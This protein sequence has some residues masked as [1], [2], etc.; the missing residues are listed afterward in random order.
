LKSEFAG[1]GFLGNVAATFGTRLLLLIIGIV[2]SV[3]IARALGPTG[4][5]M[6]AAAF[7]VTA[8][9]VQ[10]GNLGLH[11]SNTWLVARDRSLLGG[12][13]TNSLAVSALVGTVGLVI[14]AIVTTL[15][16]SV[17]PI[18][19]SLM[20]LALVSIPVSLAYLLLQNLLL[21]VG[22]IRAY[23]SIEIVNRALVV[24]G[25]VVLAIVGML[26]PFSALAV[27]LV[28]IVAAGAMALGR[29]GAGVRLPLKP[30]RTLLLDSGRYGFKAYL[31]AL[32]AFLVLRLDVLIVQ[33]LSGATATG[34]YAVAAT[35]TESL[36]IFPAVVGTLLFARL[37]ALDDH[38]TR[39]RQAKAA[40]WAVGGLMIVA[41]VLAAVF[42][43]PVIALLY[44][45]AFEPATGAFVWLMP[46]LLFLSMNTVLMNYFASRGMPLVTIAG[47]AIALGA[48]VALNLVLVPTYGIIGAAAASSVAYG[49][50][51]LA[52]I[53]AVWSADRG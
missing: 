8:I 34:Y 46:G 9:G 15:W 26:T 51:L 4:R 13:I 6:Y 23:N 40:F 25:L 39:W 19:A 48:N 10:L 30:S 7:A 37:S 5:G 33:W 20:L 14:G 32:L 50:M 1:G 28:M 52:S 49:L 38:E 41:V 2:I 42:A 24:G 12:L 18:P 3:I 31:A 16:P 35:L 17:S 44:G 22:D 21:G 36:Y 43:E 47:P 29:A 11:A 27:S 53:V 45:I